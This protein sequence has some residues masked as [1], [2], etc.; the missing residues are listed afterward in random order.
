MAS[1]G[2][3]GALFICCILCL[4]Q[5]GNQYGRK[6]NEIIKIVFNKFLTIK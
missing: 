3:K 5:P 4:M 1:S 2:I 6:K